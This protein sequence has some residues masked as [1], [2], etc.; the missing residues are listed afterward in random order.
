[1]VLQCLYMDTASHEKKPY[2]IGVIAIAYG[3]FRPYAYQL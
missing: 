2:F 1:M 3:L